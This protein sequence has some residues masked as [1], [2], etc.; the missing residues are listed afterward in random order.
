MTPRSWSRS[1]GAAGAARAAL[2]A[3]TVTVLN[4]GIAAP[5][6]PARAGPTDGPTAYQQVKRCISDGRALEPL[7]SAV[8]PAQRLLGY[9]Q[10]WALSR[11]DGVT[12]AVIDT[13]VNPSPAFGTRLVSGGDLVQP[14][15]TRAG[16]PQPG[17][18]DCDGH[19]TLVAGIIAA[20][21]DPKTGFA[22]VAP[23]ARIV[24]IR[25]NSEAFAPEGSAS[26]AEGAGT[27]T[28]LAQALDLAVAAGVDVD[29]VNISAAHC[30]PAITVGDPAL[31]SAVERAVQRDVVVVVAAGNLGS[32]GDCST[33]NTPGQRP[34]TGATPSSIPAALTVGS[35]TTAGAPADFSLASEWVDVAAP[36]ERIISTNPHREQTGQVDSVVGAE[37]VVPIQGT[38]FSAPYVAGV[39]ALVRARFPDLTAEQVMHRIAVT[40]DH[41]AGPGERTIYVGFGTINPRRAL[42]AVLA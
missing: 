25:Q 30:G 6:T 10:L 39:A 42:T 14:A 24:S 26:S 21:P 37:G 1:R 5:A 2:A 17:L 11:G 22:G 33:Q 41:P 8:S 7:A 32:G 29:V 28:T 3:A 12:V 19:G 35:V 36:G 27:S 40:A 23:G 20:T 34:V 9:T 15:A 4:T 18:D 13:G 38:S 31:T 16:A